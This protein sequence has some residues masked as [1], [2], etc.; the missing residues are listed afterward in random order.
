MTRDQK[1]ISTCLTPHTRDSPFF[2]AIEAYDIVN[3][4]G[5]DVVER[6]KRDPLALCEKGEPSLSNSGIIRI[7]RDDVAFK[8]S[9]LTRLVY[10]D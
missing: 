1:Y 9:F 6:D 7:L 2:A 3:S 8:S 10:R 5:Y 4:Y